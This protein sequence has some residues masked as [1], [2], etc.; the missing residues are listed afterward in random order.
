M[1]RRNYYHEEQFTHWPNTPNF[2]QPTNYSAEQQHFPVRQPTPYEL[3]AKPAQPMDWFQPQK[4]SASPADMVGSFTDN[5]GQVDFD[6]VLTSINQVASTYHQVSPIVKQLS[7]LIK[8][9]KQ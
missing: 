1:D 4:Q 7:S 9:F 8:I 6:K 3:Y 2:Y 5:N